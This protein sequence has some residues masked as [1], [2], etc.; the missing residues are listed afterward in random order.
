MAKMGMRVPPG[1]TIT[2]KVCKEFHESGKQLPS[3][4]WDEVKNAMSEVEK[5]MEKAFGGGQDPL[6]VSVRSGAAVSMPGMMD[7]ILNLGLNDNTVET[8]AEKT[9]TW[10]AYDSYR[11][12]LQMFGDVVVEGLS[13]SDFEKKIEKKKLQYKVEKD[14]DIPEQGMKEL[15]EEFKGVYTEKNKEFPQDPYSQLENAIYAVFNSWNNDRAIKYRAINN[16]QG[17]LG[18]AVNVQTMAFGNKGMDSGTGVLFSRNPTTGEAKIY[19]DF[20][21]K[22]Q[23]EDVVAGIRTPDSWE[24][25]EER[26]NEVFQQLKQTCQKLESFYKDMQDIEFTI[27]DGKLFMLQCRS[28][29][30]TGMAAVKCAVEMANEKLITKGEAVQRVDAKH[31][32]QMLHPQL[33]SPDRFEMLGKGLNASP[34]AAVGKVVFESDDAEKQSGEGK[35]VVLIRKETAS[36]DIG[37]MWASE[38]ILTQ[39]GGMTSHAAVVARGWGKPAVV[40]CDQLDIDEANK[41]LRIG[42]TTLKE[43][44]DISVDGTSG[45]F[46][47]GALEV[48]EPKMSGDLATLMQW[49]D[50]LRTMSV[51]ANADDP[52]SASKA[53]KNGAEGIGLCRTE[54]M[55]FNT[56]ERLKA[57]QAM[58]LAM[59][60]GTRQKALD[61]LKSFQVEDFKGIFRAMEELPVTVRLLDPPLH[62]FIPQGEQFESIAKALAQEWGVGVEV[63]RDRA[64]KLKEANPMMGLRGC[65]LGIYYPEVTRM[66]AEAILEAAVTVMNSGAR[67]IP[68][69]MV[70]LV[71]TSGEFVEQ[72]KVIDDAAREVFKRNNTAVQ[73]KV[74]TMIEIPRA[75]LK[76]KDIAEHA[77]FFSFGTNDLTQFGMGLSRDDASK[78]LKHYL[79]LGLLKDDPFQVLDKEGV[80]QLV[81]MG[82]SRGKEG[83]RHLKLGLCGEHGGH[84]GSVMFSHDAGLHY[85]SCSP[86][87]VPT[88]RLGAAQGAARK[89]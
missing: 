27:E 72:K 66:Q 58:I 84:P 82:A 34:G 17:L 1:F 6:L 88:A 29:K 20:L 11:R 10:F 68:E 31:L 57:M 23:G 46:Y 50:E 28:A 81:E 33:K 78:F 61:K 56:E 86:F 85:V 70:P 21:P 44:D 51:C 16:I 30:R 36:D 49:V 43:G 83:N 3:G 14:A 55:F 39:R 12:L 13:N 75:A 18:T 24:V 79:E 22:A 89:N 40:G 25:L 48:E 37:G 15:V 52:D 64:N 54:H 74:G 26:N 59:D 73:Y 87:R 80:G 53:R 42:N 41:T 71:A 4:V 2:T 63:L 8:F 47:K 65:R 7:T 19:G 76:A 67:V 35:K 38:G 62:E 69:I 32:E 60:K 5:E 45:K 9:N 77:D